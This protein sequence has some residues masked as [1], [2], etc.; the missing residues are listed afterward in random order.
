M[1]H[2]LQQPNHIAHS[3]RLNATDISYTW[4]QSVQRRWEDSHER[5]KFVTNGLVSDLNVAELLYSDL[6]WT[7][8]L[9]GH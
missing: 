3:L 5:T 8:Q 2:N 1:L 9:N 6:H 7:N 4:I